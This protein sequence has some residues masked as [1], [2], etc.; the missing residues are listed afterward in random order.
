MFR[1]FLALGNLDRHEGTICYTSFQAAEVW[2]RGVGRG[3]SPS[4]MT[5]DLMFSVKGK[6]TVTVI[7]RPYLRHNFLV[8]CPWKLVI[9]PPPSLSLSLLL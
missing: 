3:R 5:D 4:P 1:L 6:E 2:E 7:A 9:I 8:P